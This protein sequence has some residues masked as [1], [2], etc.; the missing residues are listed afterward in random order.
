M[1]R[2]GIGNYTS[3]KVIF[4]LTLFTMLRSLREHKKKLH[5]KLPHSQSAFDFWNMAALILAI[6][7]DLSLCTLTMVSST[8]D[9]WIHTLSFS[10]FMISA[11][12]HFV[13]SLLNNKYAR[14]PF[15]EEERRWFRY[16]ITYASLH[17]GI[18]LF[19]IYLYWRHNKFCEPGIYSIFALCEYFVVLMNICFHAV[20][21]F[22]W[23]HLK[24]AIHDHN[25][26]G[27]DE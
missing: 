18:F 20:G 10:S 22:E 9:K 3:L 1:F 25:L 11:H 14:T 15:T 7:E 2:F 26:I 13:A 27:K 19:A 8:D 16:R 4:D 17:F 23:G 5:G 24:Y 12:L 21:F 6:I